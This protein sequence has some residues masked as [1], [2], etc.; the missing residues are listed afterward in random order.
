[1]ANLA[2]EIQS[3]SNC[4]ADFSLGNPV[5]AQAYTGLIAYQPSYHAGCLTD[6]DGKYCFANA[7]TNSSAP[8]SSYIYYL[9]LGVQLPGGTQPTCDTCLQK[10]MSMFASYATNS[11]QPLS[12][13]Y[14]SAAQQVDMT[15]GP[16]F[17]ASAAVS[18]GAA[19]AISARSALSLLTTTIVASVILF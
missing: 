12:M 11:S 18:T 5:V 8:T 14:G 10:T 3:D 1:M 19:P 9:P 4:G 16:S 7:V 15:C 6:S 17:A 13:D 2:N